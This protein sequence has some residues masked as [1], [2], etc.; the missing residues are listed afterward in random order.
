VPE[1]LE[2]QNSKMREIIDKHFNDNWVVPI[3]MGYTVDLSE[4]WSPYK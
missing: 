1:N 2:S 4:Q 3:Y